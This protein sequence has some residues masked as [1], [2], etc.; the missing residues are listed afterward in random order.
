MEKSWTRQ[1]LKRN[2]LAE[3]VARAIHWIAKHRDTALAGAL[4]LV[5]GSALLAYLVIHARAVDEQAWY[6]LTI[7]QSLAGQGQKDQALKALDEFATRFRTTSAYPPS[8]LMKASL[9]AGNKHPEALQLYQTLL[10]MHDAKMLAPLIY[11]ALGATQEDA[12]QLTQARATY[13]TFVD[14]FQDHF[15]AP[16]VY[17]SLARVE[18]ALANPGE[19]RGLYEK[20]TARYP[21]TPWAEHAQERLT[22][23]PPVGTSTPRLQNS[24]TKPR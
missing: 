9:L 16:R 20:L 3:F 1:A 2:E 23:L 21:N 7:A 12:H 14:R 11:C 4:T 13:R 15:L 5:V 17:E 24:I 10:G 6:Q 8:L 19:A 22:A 18:E